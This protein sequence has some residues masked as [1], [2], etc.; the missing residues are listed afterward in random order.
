M[1]G[2]EAFCRKVKLCSIHFEDKWV[3]GLYL[4]FNAIPTLELGE[5][6]I[7]ATTYNIPCVAANCTSTSSI[8]HIKFF[9]FPT[10]PELLKQ[11][12]SILNV[13]Q[14][15]FRKQMYA[16][17]FHFDECY[18]SLPCLPKGVLPFQKDSELN[19]DGTYHENE[20]S[21]KNNRIER[22]KQIIS[23]NN[24][25]ENSS[26]SGLEEYQELIEI[27]NEEDSFIDESVIANTKED[28]NMESAE[29]P[30]LVRFEITFLD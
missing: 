22:T 11:W 24:E 2:H 19:R 5:D 4:K 30:G 20:E 9:K 8:E 21:E 7:F 28:N 18:W 17:K 3:R 6:D 26:T 12:I 1:Q 23:V 25:I 14:G 15:S 27:E 29:N 13:E 16:C 10:D